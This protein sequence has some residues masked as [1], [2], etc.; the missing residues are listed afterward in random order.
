MRLKQI[1]ESVNDLGRLQVDQIGLNTDSD[2]EISN[3]IREKC[4]ELVLNNA[5][6]EEYKKKLLNDLKKGLAK[7]THPT[8]IVKC[9]ITYV[10]DLPDGSETGK[11]LALDLGGTNFRVLLIELSKNH[12]EMRS[13]IFAIPQHIMLGS[14]EQ[15]F[16][17]IADCLAKFAK[18]EKIQNEVLPLGFTFSFPLMQKGLTKGILERW[19]K[20]FNCSNVIGN[21]VVQMLKDAI[22][23]RGDIQIEVC[24]I[25][26]DTTG[27]L[28]SCAWKNRYCKIGLII[29]TG[30]NACYV[31]DQKNAEMFDEPDRGSGKVLINCE[32]GA[33][34]DDG[35]LD[36]VRTQYDREVDEHTV[37]PGKQLHEKM[38][39]GMYMGELVRLALER[40]TNEGLLFGGKGS[41]QLFTRDRFY[42]KYVSEIESDPPGTF[43]HCK[44][45]LEE[46]GLK[47]ATEQDCIH[48]RYVCE[49]ISRRAA[50]LASA[51]IATLLNKMKEPRV[52]VG[53]DG[54]LYR[55]HPHFHNLMMEKISELVD[56]GI[57]FDLMLSEDGSGRGA[58]LVAAV[59]SRK[60]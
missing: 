54:S 33:F 35:A 8:S 40:F 4:Q 16:D 14:G 9:F 46:L 28:M 17:H 58:A 10:Q 31:E 24:A 56:P 23:R 30:T 42:T 26:N 53:I 38:I 52:T 48:V 2:N 29:G 44:E 18:D 45:I 19:T 5:Q 37:N 22:D 47:H 27:T 60:R 11:F 59:A 21:D 25:L 13:K 7:A 57:V 6:L 1:I 12:F 3:E 50:H 39:S 20:G 49:C 55:F 43:T 34:G 36:F 32:W 41:D 51:G 15:L